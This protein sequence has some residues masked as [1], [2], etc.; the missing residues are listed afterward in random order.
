MSEVLVTVGNHQCEA[1]HLKPLCIPHHLRDVDAMQRLQ[2][3]V[4]TRAPRPRGTLLYTVGEARQAFYFL[5]SGS[6]KAIVSDEQGV[7]CV[8]SFFYPTDIIGASS[9]EHSVY[10]ESVELLERSAVCEIRASA[11]EDL[12]RGDADFLH[13]LLAKIASSFELERA[14]RLRNNHASSDAR[15]ADFLLEIGRRMHT[16]GRCVDDLT[17]SMSRYD[18]ASHLC[19]A[20]ETVSRGFRRLQENRL[21]DVRGKHIRILDPVALQRR[22]RE[23]VGRGAGRLTMESDEMARHHARSMSTA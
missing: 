2:R 22:A 18:I 6:A 11:L 12:C 8:A 9:L 16:I 4:V 21:I 13:G 20:A 10:L 17:L 5:R 1:C 15:M 19:M 3:I 14:A 7:E 23:H